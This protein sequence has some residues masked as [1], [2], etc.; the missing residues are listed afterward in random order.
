M[1]KLKAELFLKAMDAFEEVLSSNVAPP[2]IQR[3]AAIQ[4]FEFTFE[5]AWKALKNL[6]Y[7]KGVD[8]N[9]PKD[10]FR[11]AFAS[12]DIQDEKI[13][14]EMLKDRNLTSHTYNEPLACEVFSHLPKYLNALN[15]L[16]PIL[17][18]Q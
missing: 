4:R 6:Y 8:L 10:V 17:N 13:W 18:D 7:E 2:S 12:G 14:L 3:D 5:L 1:K 16:K 9:S 15:S 11:H